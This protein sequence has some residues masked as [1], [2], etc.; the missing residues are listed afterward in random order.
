[1]CLATHTK[2]S[3]NYGRVLRD[4]AKVLELNPKHVKALYRSARALF[5]LDRLPEAHDCCEHGLLNDPDNAAMKQLRDKI[6][7]RIEQVEAK[8][9][10]KEERERAEKEGKARLEAAIKVRKNKGRPCA[11]P[12]VCVRVCAYLLSMGDRNAKSR[13]R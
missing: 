4:C 3:G 13:W 11:E 5:A 7:K 6:A 12:C 2:Y 8:R 1:M 10:Q 9:R